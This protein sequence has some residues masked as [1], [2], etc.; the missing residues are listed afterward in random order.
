MKSFSQESLNHFKD[1]DYII[2][3]IAAEI[4]RNED[5]EAHMEDGVVDSRIMKLKVDL[6]NGLINAHNLKF[7]KEKHGKK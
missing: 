4:R 5:I 6:L 3:Y 1:I 7:L 2:N